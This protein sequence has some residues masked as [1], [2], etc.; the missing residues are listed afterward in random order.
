MA[1]DESTMGKSAENE[2]IVDENT[3]DE[4]IAYEECNGWKKYMIKNV[5]KK[6]CDRWKNAV[7]KK[8]G[9]W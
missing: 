4:I 1:M 7:E 3:M 8:H 5:A 6:K 9:E 2:S